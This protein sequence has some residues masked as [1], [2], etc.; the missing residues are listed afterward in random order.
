[1]FILFASNL[2]TRRYLHTWQW[3]A[4][5]SY[6]LEWREYNITF[7]LWIILCFFR[8]IIYNITF[9]YELF[10]IFWHIEVWHATIGYTRNLLRNI[11]SSIEGTR[12]PN[13]SYLHTTPHNNEQWQSIATQHSSTHCCQLEVHSLHKLGR[14]IGCSY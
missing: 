9:F 6:I 14:S 5:T 4:K 13:I 12:L 10:Y 8:C 1:M 3:W 7:C 11:C 2:L